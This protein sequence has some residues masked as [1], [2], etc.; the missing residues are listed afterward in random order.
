MSLKLGW[1]RTPTR[2]NLY[3]TLSFTAFKILHE[4][5]IKIY[6]TKI[7]Q[8]YA[9][10]RK[11][12]NIF[13]ALICVVSMVRVFLV[14]MMNNYSVNFLHMLSYNFVLYLVLGSLALSSNLRT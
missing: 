13:L 6:I 3:Q 11:T 1:G 9:K 14:E 8:K 7:K 12:K 2:G 4:N 5:Q 10:L